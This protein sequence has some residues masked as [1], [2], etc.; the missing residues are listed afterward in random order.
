[1]TRAILVS[2]LCIGW[3]KQSGTFT[4]IFPVIFEKA[5]LADVELVG[6]QVNFVR[7]YFWLNFNQL[8]LK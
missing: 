1:M 5:D 4:G 2:G 8:D 3:E 7:K 6:R